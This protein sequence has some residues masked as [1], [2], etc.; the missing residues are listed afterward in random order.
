MLSDEGVVFE[1]D[2]WIH[3]VT[4][5]SAD[6]GAK[7]YKNGVLVGSGGAS[8][9]DAFARSYHWLGRDILGNQLDGTIA[10]VKT[11]HGV[12]LQQS[13]VSALYEKRSQVCKRASLL[14]SGLN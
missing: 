13:D 5:F 6:N 1:K 14:Q 8:A 11:W 10:Y 12:E 7:M 2:A 4:T 3:T 9:P